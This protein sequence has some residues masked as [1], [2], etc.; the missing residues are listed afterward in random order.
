MVQNVEIPTRAQE[1]SRIAANWL[2]RL[3]QVTRIRDPGIFKDALRLAQVTP[4]EL[5][6]GENI[7]L[8]QLNT[9]QLY[10]RERYPDTTLKMYYQSDLLDMGLIGYAMAS[11]GTIKR[12][13]EI[14]VGYHDLT[15]DRYQLE[16]IHK[17]RFSH[18]RQIP[19]LKHL[20]EYVDIGEELAGI[21]KILHSLLGDSVDFS[22]VSISFS[23]P[24]PS[25]VSVYH[26]VFPCPCLFDAE[27]SEIIF[28]EAWLNLPVATANLSTSAVCASMCERVLGSGKMVSTTTEAVQR[29]LVSRPG[30]KILTLVETAAQLNLSVN[31]LRKRLY[32]NKTSFKQ[33][34]LEVRMALARHYLEATNLSVQEIAYL[35]GYSQ[36]AP[37]SRAFKSYTGQSPQNCRIASRNQNVSS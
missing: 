23:Y 32:R 27:Y 33:I 18:I 17:N 3:E 15:S 19:F 11:S 22:Q 14:A 10:V 21:F 37:F 1:E 5:E 35:L 2:H 34:V 13:F 12:A 9:V 36:A 20:N 28:P 6:S 24:A 4:H 31:Q 16:L 25:Y 7:H 8:H 26:E 30:H 29:L